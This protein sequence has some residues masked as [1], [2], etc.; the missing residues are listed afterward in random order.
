M[1]AIE[2]REEKLLRSL[3]LCE[4]LDNFNSYLVSLMY[5][6]YD[7]YLFHRDDAC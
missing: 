6:N 7:I 4:I 2:L 5:Y 3:S 1:K